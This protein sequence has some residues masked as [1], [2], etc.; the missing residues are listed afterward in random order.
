MIEIILSKKLDKETFLNFFGFRAGGVDF[1]GKITNV[2]SGINKKNYQ[3]CID[4]YYY[5]NY[6]ELSKTLVE[7]KSKIKEYQ[8]DFFDATQKIFKKDFSKKEYC[9]SLSI[10][11]CNP[12]YLDKN[13]FQIYYKRDVLDKIEVIF[14]EVLHFMFFDY[15][16]KNCK[17]LVQNLNCNNGI[18]W[19]LSE[20]FNII[21][22]NQSEFQ[23]ILK[24]PELIF[25]PIHKEIY[26]II[27]K[28]WNKNKGNLNDFIKESLT[29][30][31]FLH[32]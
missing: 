22:L 1:G 21:V 19:D 25:Y 17:E 18:Y 8:N 10:F 14:H 2:F 11:D 4:D 3:Q 5:Q 16:E 6:D 23:K 27:E 15:C 26:P 31:S 9:G 12:R 30:L 20:I 28:I 32:S 29:V 13:I 24:R 7:T